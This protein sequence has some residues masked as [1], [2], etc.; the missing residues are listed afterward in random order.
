[1]AQEMGVAD[2]PLQDHLRKVSNARARIHDERVVTRLHLNAA[3]I[4][5]VFHVIQRRTCDTAP[6]PPE[7]YP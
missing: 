2:I 1:M 7:F 5:A 3:G 6:N 4:T